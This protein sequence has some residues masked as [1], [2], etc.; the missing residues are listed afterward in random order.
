[1][2]VQRIRG[3]VLATVVFSGSITA[4]VALLPSL[5]SSYSRSALHI[6]LETA[7]SLIAT[8]AAFLVFGR[9]RRSTLLNELTLAA[10]LSVLAVS[11]LLFGMLPFL[12][13]PAPSEPILWM[14]LAGG[15]LGTLL[16]ALAAF[17]PRRRLPKEVLVLAGR[18]AAAAAVLVFGIA[19]IGGFTHHAA[20]H[21]GAAQQTVFGLRALP[22]TP[23]LNLVM[24]VLCGLAAIGFLSRCR[25][26]GDEFLGWLAIASVLAAASHVNYLLYPTLGSNSTYTGEA[27][28]VLFYAALLAGSMREISS[29][30]RALSVGAVLEERRRVAR[31]LHDGL[32]QELAYLARNLDL[33]DE[34]ATGETVGRLR[35]A[36]GR[37]Q[38]ES[39]RAIRALAAPS[40]QTFATVLAEAAG[41]VAER[42]HIEVLLDTV[43]D[44]RLSETRTEAMV[45][46]ACEAITNAARHSGTSLV[47]LSL[48]HDKGHVRLRVSDAGCG[49]NPDVRCEGFGLISMRERA[50]SV[51]ADL[52]ISST[53]GRGSEV[54]AVL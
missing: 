22:I 34:R 21:F 11:N 50:E 19:L 31:D 41:E 6:V 52:R 4:L 10:A 51:G 1:M 29:Y 42:F 17:V 36:V 28:R 26:L 46:I 8:L 5:H 16:F 15:V 49:F 30:W 3:A 9:V 54:E 47:R 38:L 14:F 23:A 2:V 32:A 40:G 18:T 53:P 25:Q 39:R 24:A 20:Q 43:R 13:A 27:F 12:E 48:R 7:A 44:V 35:R 45:R 37:A 33:L